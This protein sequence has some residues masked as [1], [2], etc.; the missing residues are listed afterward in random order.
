MQLSQGA[1]GLRVPGEKQEEGRLDH[2]HRVDL[3]HRKG[4]RDTRDQDRSL[5]RVMQKRHV[6]RS[7]LVTVGKNPEKPG[8]KRHL[9]PTP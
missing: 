2:C 9:S 8:L 4:S 5:K 7:G 6:G 1:P 3:G